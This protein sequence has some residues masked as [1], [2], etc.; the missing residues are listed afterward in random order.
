MEDDQGGPVGF[1]PLSIIL[2]RSSFLSD[3]FNGDPI[4]LSE[5]LI[6]TSKRDKGSD[7]LAIKLG[8]D[9]KVRLLSF[10]EVV[11]EQI[12]IF[13][14]DLENNGKLRAQMEVNNGYVPLEYLVDYSIMKS[15]MDHK[16][17]SER[18]ESLTKSLRQAISQNQ[19][20]VEFDQ[21]EKMIKNSDL[22]SLLKRQVEF[23][24]SDNKYF[25][26]KHLLEVASQGQDMF[27]PLKVICGL[28]RVRQL[29]HD[30]E[31]YVY[32]KD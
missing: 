26:D 30:K 2:S 10:E 32:N 5:S 23:Y 15:I 20:N 11:A 12:E 7:C 8:K 27:I 14:D 28:R 19:I 18:I 25:H 24:F 13:F 16:E 4:A 29:F 31:K 9:P 3:E 1:V 17:E 6:K 21:E 22:K